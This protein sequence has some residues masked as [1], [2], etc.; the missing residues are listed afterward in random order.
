MEVTDE[1]LRSSEAA[2]G[3]LDAFARRTAALGGVA[4]PELLDR[5][6][7]VMEDDLD[8][9]GAV[10]LMFTS[11]REANAAL[12]RDDATAAA[13]LAAAVTEIATTLGLELRAVAGDVPNEI[14]QLAQE[15]AAAREARTSPPPTSCATASPLPGS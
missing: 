11:L 7:A 1:V 14:L 9:P 6:R 13:P 15:R 3:R 10:E 2:L 5:F 4:A 8:T 12:D